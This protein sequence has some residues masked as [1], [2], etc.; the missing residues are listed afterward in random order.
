[1]KILLVEDN[2]KHLSEGVGMLTARGHEVVT[3]CTACDA[4]NLIRDGGFDGVIT[5]VHLPFGEK[6]P[7][8]DFSDPATPS[9]VLVALVCRDKGIP[10]V[11]CADGYHHGVKLQWV[12]DI[13]ALL[14]PGGCGWEL[15]AD[16]IHQEGEDEYHEICDTKDWECA[17][18]L[19]ERLIDQS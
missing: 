6:Y 4:K 8:A 5:D 1:M 7:H 3:A 9:G 18:S 19:L 16:G 14:A 15:M 2:A 11:F 12:H 10:F 13:C 17:L